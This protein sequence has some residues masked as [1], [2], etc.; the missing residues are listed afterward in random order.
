MPPRPADASTS[1]VAPSEPSRAPA[2]ASI[3]PA[4]SP[5]KASTLH[6]HDPSPRL[7]FRRQPSRLVRAVL[8]TAACLVFILCLTNDRLA[9]YLARSSAPVGTDVWEILQPATESG[10][11]DDA[12]G[13]PKAWLRR[14]SIT[15]Y[16][17]PAH[18]M[19]HRPKAAFISL[20]RNEELDGILQ[21]I[22]QL[23]YYFNRRHKYPWIFFSEVA[24]TDEFKAVT[25]NATS[26]PTTY[27]L[28][29]V[30]HW[31]TPPNISRSSYYDSLDY[32]GALGVGKLDL[33]SSPRR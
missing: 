33:P 2:P 15:D 14:H 29:P 8:L 24:F 20:V 30:A 17:G 31:S 9:R 26:A 6:F 13:A 1:C 7:L 28:I 11:V 18:P 16:D 22:R 25:S 5:V 19:K 3:K 21:S 12:S 10:A 4:A 23:E 27:H 32:L